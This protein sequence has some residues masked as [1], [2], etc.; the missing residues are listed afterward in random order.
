VID[1]RKALST[2]ELLGLRLRVLFDIPPRELT[3]PDAVPTL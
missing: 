2:L 1:Q 3:D